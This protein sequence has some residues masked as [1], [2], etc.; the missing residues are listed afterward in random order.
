[1]KSLVS[2]LLLLLGLLPVLPAC[3][4]GEPSTV[5][6]DAGPAATIRSSTLHSRIAETTFMPSTQTVAVYV[7]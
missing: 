3:A 4:E 6:P 2:V 7:G 5:A 1:M